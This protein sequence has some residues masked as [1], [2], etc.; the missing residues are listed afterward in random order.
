[1]TFSNETD[2][3][4]H[5]LPK[6]TDGTEFDNCLM[7]DRSTVN[8]VNSSSLNETITIKCTNGWKYDY[9]LV[10]ETIVSENDW[11][12]DEQWKALFAHSLFSIGMA[13][14]SMSVGILSDII[15]RVRTIAIFFT[16]AGISGTLTTFSVHNYVLFAA[17]RI[18]LGFS[19]PIIAVP[20]VLLAE[21]VGTEK[22][23]IAL[24]GFF[25]AFSTFNGLS[26]WIAYLIGNWRLFNLVT[27]LL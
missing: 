16:I 19:A 9:N 22:R 6:K 15:G 11:V 24:L 18:V 23:F 27:S 4:S 5:F 20:T 1:M 7:F 8:T 21:V 13:F 25:L 17:C 10:L 2:V 14:G 3:D 26:P 12:C